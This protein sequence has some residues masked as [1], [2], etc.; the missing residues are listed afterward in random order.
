MPVVGVGNLQHHVGGGHAT[1]T[2]VLDGVL[3]PC[4]DGLAHGQQTLEHWP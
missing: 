4:D 1:Q 2:V 3:Q